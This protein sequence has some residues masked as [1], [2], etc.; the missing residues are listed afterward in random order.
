[1]DAVTISYFSIDSHSIKIISVNSDG[2]EFVFVF[3]AS[4]IYCQYF[5]IL[6]Y[7]YLVTAFLRARISRIWTHDSC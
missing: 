3:F 4:N 5:I 2:I 6:Q 1:M 7:I